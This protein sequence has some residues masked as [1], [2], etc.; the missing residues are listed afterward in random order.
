[1]TKR[2][3][4]VKRKDKELTNPAYFEAI[5][6]RGKYI[7]LALCRNDEPYIVTMNYGYD[8]KLNALFFLCALEGEKLEF[9]SDN[10]T[11]CGSIIEDLGYGHGDC[12]HYYRS[13]VIRGN[14]F[15]VD[16][17]EE[18]KHGINVMIDHLEEHPDDVKARL[19]KDRK[20]YEKMHILRFE[21]ENITGQEGLKKPVS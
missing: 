21:I 14:I 3:Y 5:I 9:L 15:I 12:E 7:T 4:H 10:P 11:V 17:L 18:K 20:I 13:L 8:T 6:K 2:R 1:M 16:S 19:L